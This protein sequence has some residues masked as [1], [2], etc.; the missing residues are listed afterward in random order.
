ML[1]ELFDSMHMIVCRNVFL[2]RVFSCIGRVCV[3]CE[4]RGM[5]VCV[6]KVGMYVLCDL[7]WLCVMY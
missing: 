5:S 1:C 4:L 7:L 6:G 2:I 3:L